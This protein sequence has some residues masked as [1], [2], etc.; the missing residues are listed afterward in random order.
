MLCQSA[1]CDLALV[2]VD[3]ETFW[4][5]LP[6]VVFQESVPELDDT[7]CAVGYPL[8]ASSVTLTRGVVRREGADRTRDAFP[9]ARAT[10]LEPRRLGPS[11]GE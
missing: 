9:S 5:G 4:E 3:D 6:S 1:V 10:R 11:Q 8:G 2:T 7:V